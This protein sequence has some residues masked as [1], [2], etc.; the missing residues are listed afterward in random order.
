[1]KGDVKAKKDTLFI[2]VCDEAHSSST[3]S[4]QAKAESAYSK[5]VNFWKSDE[6]PNVLVFMVSGNGFICHNLKN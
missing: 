5:I 2:I 4:T 1:L 3:N 6:H